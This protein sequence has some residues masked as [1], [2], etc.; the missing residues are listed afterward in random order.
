MT[1]KDESWKGVMCG[2]ADYY[3]MIDEFH[4][5]PLRMD[6]KTFAEMADF[7]PCECG[8]TVLNGAKYRIDG[9]YSAAKALFYTCTL[10][11]QITLYVVGDPE[12]FLSKL[13]VISVN[14]LYNQNQLLSESQA[15]QGE[16]SQE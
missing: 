1:K 10:C 14:S 16:H 9:L 15:C 6:A 5:M 11:D 12:E 3:K 2:Y 13:K 7:P 4:G 8:T